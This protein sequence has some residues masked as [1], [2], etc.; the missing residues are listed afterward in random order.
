MNE[1]KPRRNHQALAESRVGRRVAKGLRVLGSYWVGQDSTFKFFEVNI[2]GAPVCSNPPNRIVSHHRWSASIPSTKPSVV[3]RRST[4]SVPLF[5]S[6]VNCVAWLVR[7]RSIVVCVAR[8]AATRRWLVAHDAVTGDDVI[9][10]NFADEDKQKYFVIQTITNF[11]S[12]RI[13]FYYHRE[14]FLSLSSQGGIK[15]QIVAQVRQGCG[16]ITWQSWSARGS[17]FLSKHTKMFTTEIKIN[18]SESRMKK[19]S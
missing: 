10:F 15:L 12:I 5:K 11:F 13:L 4:G 6:T 9:H 19:F 14:R 8:D 17:S 18:L 7:A 1:L 3:M 2:P 16:H